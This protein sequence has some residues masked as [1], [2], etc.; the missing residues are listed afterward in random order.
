VTVTVTVTMTGPKWHGAVLREGWVIGRGSS[1]EGSGHSIGSPWQGSWPQ[2]ARVQGAFG[3][4]SQ[5]WGVLGSSCVKVGV[6]FDS[7]GSL[8]TLATIN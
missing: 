4:H 6:G 5:I 2:A 1:P 7:F 3:R 8:P